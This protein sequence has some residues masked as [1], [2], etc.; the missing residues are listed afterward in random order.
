M[1]RGMV[2]VF[3]RRQAGV[4]F[5]PDPATRAMRRRSF[6]VGLGLPTLALCARG[7]DSRHDLRALVKNPPDVTKNISRSSQGRLS[8]ERKNPPL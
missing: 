4:W 7:G 1:A 2:S 8:L 3:P 6:G 5:L